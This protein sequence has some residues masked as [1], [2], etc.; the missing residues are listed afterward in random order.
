MKK[1]SLKI[2]LNEAQIAQFDFLLELM[3]IFESKPKVKGKIGTFLEDQIRELNPDMPS[4]SSIMSS[5]QGSK[6][7]RKRNDVKS[8]IVKKLN[9]AFKGIDGN[10]LEFDL[11]KPL[12]H[13]IILYLKN[14]ADV[15]FDN[16]ILSAEYY[17]RVF[18]DSSPTKEQDLIQKGNF[19]FSI[20]F[21]RTK[22]YESFFK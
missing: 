12:H 18:Y 11:I 4:L 14:S 15:S 3:K 2:L 21:E 22:F 20:I 10:N 7:K 16:C 13:S 19:D 17:M 8:N 9:E 1:Y 5:Y 6:N